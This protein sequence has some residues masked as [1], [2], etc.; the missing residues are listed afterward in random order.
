MSCLPIVSVSFP[1]AMKRA[2]ET[3]FNSRLRRLWRFSWRWA[4]SRGVEELVSAPDFSSWAERFL[5]PGVAI[6]AESGWAS[7][8]VAGIEVVSPPSLELIVAMPRHGT[9][10]DGIP[11]Q[12]A[13]SSMTLKSLRRRLSGCDRD[14]K[15]LM[16]IGVEDAQWSVQKRV[17]EQS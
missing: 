5:F 3:Y 16:P 8:F 15:L 12:Q 6:A 10:V 14:A 11:P 1:V 4:L 7:P 9:A 2:R 13:R 17:F